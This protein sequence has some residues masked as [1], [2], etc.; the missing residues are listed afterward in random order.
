MKIY[1][2]YRGKWNVAR[3]LANPFRVNWRHG[4]QRDRPNIRAS[5][6]SILNCREAGFFSR[7]L[8]S[9]PFFPS[10]W[11]FVNI[12]NTATLIIFSAHPRE[13]KIIFQR[14]FERRAKLVSR[15]IEFGRWKSAYRKLNDLSRNSANT[16][17]TGYLTR[18]MKSHEYCGN[19]RWSSA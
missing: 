8:F 4:T 13:W 11:K 17:N 6:P 15:N 3:W 7:D 14:Y 18:S 16:G 12:P 19:R 5:D 9:L 10:V 2:V 1:W